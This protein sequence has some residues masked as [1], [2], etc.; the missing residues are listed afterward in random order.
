MDI[1]DKQKLCSKHADLLCVLGMH[2]SG[3]SAVTRF[4]HLLGAAHAPDLLKAME[5]VNQDG[6]WEDQRVVDINEQ[7]LKVRGCHWYDLKLTLPAL[8]V[9]IEKQLRNKAVDHFDK[10]YVINT[11]SV[12]KDPRL[13]RMLP[14][15][16]DVWTASKIQP[17]FV[18]IVRHPYAV[19]KSL[20]KRDNIPYEYAIVL[21]LF[22]TLDA[23][24]IL[25]KQEG[26]IV[27]YDNFLQN[28]LK[29]VD[30]LI[31]RYHIELFGDRHHW[32]EAAEQA[33]NNDLRHNNNFIDTPMGLSELCAFSASLYEAISTG[34]SDGV[35]SLPVEQWREELCGLL[36]RYDSDIKMLERLCAKLMAL[37]AENV[38]IGEL[39]SN[40]LSTIQTKDAIIADKES[41]IKSKD[42]II[43][44]REQL[45][46]DIAHFRI[47]RL[48]PR[49]W[50]K[51]KRL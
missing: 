5:G 4:L 8:D 49:I 2:R 47:R 16:L 23:L 10:N 32:C 42:L 15:W 30:V 41:I 44:E 3:T 26:L 29:L 1:N 35:G 43:A 7:L 19:A 9:L 22:Y 28:P 51:V 11:L 48:A 13:C 14:F 25:R 39:H 38:R 37:S 34:E 24:T 31:S 46:G 12:V 21:W 50:R 40:A 20:Q 6:F 45:I 17:I 33:I 36:M 18:Y 27:N